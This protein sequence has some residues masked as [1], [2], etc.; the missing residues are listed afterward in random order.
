MFV[1]LLLLLFLHRTGTL[2]LQ[3]QRLFAAQL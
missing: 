1:L 3:L 2:P